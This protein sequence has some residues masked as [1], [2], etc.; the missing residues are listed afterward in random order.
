M[1]VQTKVSFDNST[2]DAK[3]LRDDEDWLVMPLVI[4]SEIVQ[5]YDDGYAYKSADELRKMIET[6]ELVGSKP[7][8]ILSHPGADTD[9]LVKRNSDT[10]GKVTNFRFEESPRVR[11]LADAWWSKK[12]T[13]ANVLD[14]IRGMK[15]RDCS[16]GF[17][18]DSVTEHGVW[19]GQKFD[20]RQTNIFLDH[21]AAPI[22][23]GRCPGPIC[24][25]GY[26]SKT[27]VQLD[28]KV[29]AAC[30]VCAHMKDAGFETAGKRLYQAYGPDVLEVIDTGYKPTATQMDMDKQ[31]TQIFSELKKQLE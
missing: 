24:G 23:A 13:P 20:Y 6:A 30:P 22:P 2:I 31:F 5:Q 19:N 1:S 12:R 3:V 18:Y 9:Y 7:I 29:L 26:D 27:S 17:T 14:D 21:V 28:A 10:F 16:I 11:V 15:M 25:I 8:K 4:A